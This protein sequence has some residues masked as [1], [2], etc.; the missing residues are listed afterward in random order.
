MQNPQ[1]V[2]IMERYLDK[3]RFLT[4]EILLT[5]KPPKQLSSTLRD[6]LGTHKHSAPFLSVKTFTVSLT[7]LSLSRLTLFW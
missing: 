2:H 1:V 6:Y 3:D 5:L 4:C 7:N